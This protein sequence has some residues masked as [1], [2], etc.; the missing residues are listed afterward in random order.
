MSTTPTECELILD[1]PL[2]AD[3]RGRLYLG[4]ERHAARLALALSQRERETPEHFLVNLL[5]QGG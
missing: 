1:R 3:D 5:D 4:W 2:G